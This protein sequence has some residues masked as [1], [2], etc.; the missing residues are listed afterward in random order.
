MPLGFE[1]LNERSQRPNPLINFIKPLDTPHKKTS[2]EFLS[3]IAAQCYPIMKKHHISVMALEEYE[4]NP[5]FLGRNFNAG[6]VIQLVLKDKQGRWLSMEFVQMVMMHELAH[7]KQMNH[8]RS[9]WGVRNEYAKQMEEL[10]AQKYMGE[11]MWGRGRGLETGEWLN[12]AAPDNSPIPE[13]LCGGSYRR[14][15][16]KRKRGQQGGSDEPEKLSYAERQQ[17]RIARKFGKHGVSM[18]GQSLGDDELLRGALETMNGGKRGTGKPRVANSKRGRELRAAAALAR[19][20]QEKSKPPEKTPDLEDDLDSE[21]ESEWEGDDD[22]DAVVISDGHGHDL[23]KVCGEGEDEEEDAGRE[24]DELRMLSAGAKGKIG[25]KQ[26]SGRGKA[27]PMKGQ[28]GYEDSETESEADDDPVE[29]APDGDSQSFLGDPEVTSEADRSQPA[30]PSHPSEVANDSLPASQVELLR[31]LDNGDEQNTS[32]AES[33]APTD[34]TTNNTRQG[35]A[36]QPQACPICS[37]ENEAGA[38]TCMACSNVLR[39]KLVPNS[40]RCKSD[41]CKESTYI[42]AG[43][44]GRCGLCGAQKPKMMDSTSSGN[45]SDRPMGF[46]RPEVLRWD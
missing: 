23:V 9:F 27:P 46:T 34:Q 14:R 3:R 30:P 29:S 28:A 19:F 8:S 36:A 11:G 35:T 20:D 33:A 25:T 26:A 12:A 42:N 1:R 18:E 32:E 10:W 44:V 21:T 37:L 2:E 43:D 22:G 45:G 5:E 31:E 40:W 17:K 41:T 39:P 6:E 16:K 7:C 15:G 4:P 38:P 13:H 24:M